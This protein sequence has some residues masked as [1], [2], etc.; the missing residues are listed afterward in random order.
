VL[1]KIEQD[2]SNKH[3]EVNS[4]AREGEAVH[5]SI[6]VLLN[7]C[8]DNLKTTQK[9]SMFLFVFGVLG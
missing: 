3:R 2:E 5:A 8:I 9:Y 4:C 6:I 1:V 7:V